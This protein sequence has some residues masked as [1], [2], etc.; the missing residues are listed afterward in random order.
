MS[1]ANGLTRKEN[2][3]ICQKAAYTDKESY[4]Q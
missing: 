1:V 3:P 2:E 4:Q